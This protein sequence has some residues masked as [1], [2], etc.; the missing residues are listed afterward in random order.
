[1]F[2]ICNSLAGLAEWNVPKGGMFL[3]IKVNGVKDT[4]EMVMARGLDKK[5]ILVPGKCFTADPSKP[6]AY[7]RAAFSLAPQ[8]DIDEVNAK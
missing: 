4:N 7:I 5:I 6:S 2:K 3:W 8:D 1:M